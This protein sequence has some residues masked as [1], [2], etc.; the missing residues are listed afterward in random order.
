MARYRSFGSLDDVTVE[1]GD[2]GFTGVNLRLPTWQLAPGLLA[3]SE[4][5]RIDGDWTP[6]RGIDVVAEG[7]LATSQP[8]RL[9][10]WLVDATGGLF[11]D[12]VE[13]VG[14]LVTIFTTNEHGLPVSGAPALVVVSAGCAVLY[15]ADASGPA[16]AAISITYVIQAGFN[17]LIVSVVDSAITVT[18][19]DS[20]MM[21]I[22]GTGAISGS[23]IAPLYLYRTTSSGSFPRWQNG[24]WVLESSGDDGIWDLV[25]TDLGESFVSPTLS[26]TPAGIVY[27]AAG[28]S[29]S[30]VPTVTASTANGNQVIAKVNA[31][32]FAGAL[33]TAAEASPGSGINGITA[34]GPVFLQGGS[35]AGGAYLGLKLVTAPF[36]I[37]PNGVWFMNPTGDFSLEFTIPGATGN[38]VYTLGSARVISELNDTAA[39]EVLGSCLFSDPSSNNDESI[40]LAFGSDVK[41]VSLS[42]GSVTSYGLPGNETLDETVDMVQAMDKVFIFRAGEIAFQWKVGDTD[43]SEV[44]SGT[45]TQ[46]QVFQVTG[47]FVDV[48]SGLCTIT[49]LTNNTVATNDSI[50]IYDTNDPHFEEFKGKNYFV[51]SANATSFSFYI[52]VEDLS[53]I[54]TNTLSIGRQVSIGGG[55]IH[56]PAFPWAIYFQRRLWGPYWYFWDTS[57][58]P[59]AFTDRNIRDEL[60]A[61]DILDSDTYDPLTNQFRIT[62]GTAD[63]IVALHPFYDDVLLVM[64]R[65]SIHGV[66]GTVGTLGDTSVKELTREIGC[67]ARKSVVSQG[68]KIFFLS[69]SGVY[70]LNFYNDYNLRGVERPLSENIQPYMDRLSNTLAPESVGIY[71]NNRYYLAVPLDSS[72]GAGDAVGNNALLIYNLMNLQ[73]ESVDTF[74]DPAFLINNLIIGRSGKRNDL[75]AV[76]L[77]GGIHVLEKNDSDYDIIAT[78]FVTGSQQ[79][80]IPAVMKTR[81]YMCETPERK[82]FITMGVQMKAGTSQTDVGLAFTAEDP[83]NS[84]SETLVSNTMGGPLP[85]DETADVRQRIGGVRGFNGQ[86]TLR[87]DI[88]RPS[89]RS[90][91][92]QATVTNRE[93]IT[94]K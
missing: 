28:G 22:G 30:G 10:F 37:D 62:D 38:E 44:E 3:L 59:D 8:L 48:V 2:V 67:L 32:V 19:G 31:D 86:V 57:L 84:G 16:G 91:K 85:T 76:T 69:D 47:T 54:G 90:V 55:F 9:P 66:F 58:T 25:N 94:Q 45:Y 24:D 35:D 56:Q 6:R 43:F 89:I 11:V 63:Y 77:A 12:S 61:S 72:P 21:V 73:W 46:P 17:D 4:N 87:R 29:T 88:G 71:F 92:V 7:S 27:Q 41:R 49:G 93:T 20:A 1:D 13:R 34:T 82:R 33:V 23:P 14:N 60:I 18:S 39:D 51:Q 64:N 70:V 74:G 68:G 42:D 83:D 52:P 26:P 78:N 79:F 53:T 40:F 75:Y 65:N 15:T 81:A 50:L 36:T 5:G 80:A